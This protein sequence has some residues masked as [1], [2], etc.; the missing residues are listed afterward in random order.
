[1]CSVLVQRRNIELPHIVKCLVALQELGLPLRR[2][3]RWLLPPARAFLTTLPF[4]ALNDTA[5]TSQL[6][7]V[8]RGLNRCY[9]LRSVGF[10]DSASQTPFFL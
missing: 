10:G 1:M 3:D 8:S 9:V 4:L 2:H 7:C 6:Y 5:V